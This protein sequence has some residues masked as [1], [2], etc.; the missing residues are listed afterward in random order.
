[1][2]LRRL[3][4]PLLASVF[5]YGGIGVIRSPEGAAA[6]VKPKLMAVVP[7]LERVMEPS[8]V[9]SVYPGAGSG[10]KPVP[11]A[12]VLV[13][14]DG[15]LKVAAGSLLALGLLPR[16][17]ATALAVSLVPTTLV[18]H[19]FWKATDPQVRNQQLIQFLKN[20][21]LLGGLILEAT[22]S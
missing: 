22:E 6:A 20:A 17:S 16:L 9:P 10:Q 14:A 4:R 11:I 13:Q 18:G 15:G 2:N 12:E 5:I 3:A 8:T 7:A 1:M 21:G 19:A